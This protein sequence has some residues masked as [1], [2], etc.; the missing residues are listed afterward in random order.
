[1]RRSFRRLG[2]LLTGFLVAATHD[3]VKAQS[4]TYTVT[5]LGHFEEPTGMN[6]AGDVVGYARVGGRWHALL[7]RSGVLTDLGT[8]GAF[9]AIAFDIND[10]GQILLTL[11][12]SGGTRLALWSNGVVT[13]IGPTTG[14]GDHKM[15]SAGD[16][17]GE[18]LGNPILYSNG[19]VHV[20]P[21]NGCGNGTAHDVNE[22]A[23]IVV[24]RASFA[25]CGN[26]DTPAVWTNGVYQRLV[27]PPGAT[28]VE[29][30][31]INASG[32]IGVYGTSLLLY[33]P[34]GQGGYTGQNLGQLPGTTLC[35]PFGMNDAAVM[36][37]V[38][39]TTAFIWDAEHGL[40]DL[41]SLAA[42]PPG[43][44]LFSGYAVSNAGTIL[45]MG[46]DNGVRHGY[47]LTPIGNQPPVADAGSAQVV[48][49][50]ATVSLD[51]SASFDDNTATAQLAFSWTLASVPA[52]SAAQLTGANTM[53][54]TFVPDVVGNYVARLVVTDQNG[55]DSAPSDVVVTPNPP[56]SADAGLDQVVLVSSIVTLSGSASDA[57]G[58][59]L[60]FA[61]SLTSRPPG[62]SASPSNANQLTA[63]FIPD[64]AG[65]YIAR[66]TVS[67]PVGD[68]PPD[69]VRITATTASQY[70][71]TQIQAA[72]SIA[73]SLPSTAV[74]TGGNQNALSG[75]LAA[76]TVALDGGDT[77]EAIHKLQQAIS[78][79]DGCALLGAPDGNGPGRDWVT[80]CAAQENIY[81]LLR[82]A[83]EVLVP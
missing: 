27:S 60:S 28:A 10:A 23:S 34:D 51:G 44:S 76:A 74:T 63:S 47:L 1:M 72:A 48:R 18:S 39:G 45:A 41:T 83:L 57:D 64:V 70:A 4:A 9:D 58:D 24:G 37:G 7:W 52:G 8:F 35:A 25:A 50:G 69:E 16:V 14:Y 43:V 80:T 59:P 38:C 62:S 22:N 78:R 79:T 5:D 21:I 36:V 29:A 30:M 13:D 55:A 54:P 81:P 56:P 17:A 82:A 67:D 2:L 53:T 73:V 71:V 12:V 66:L 19:V 31:R 3:S 68:G 33:E 49:P 77:A 26:S 61:W 65:T 75:F 32:Q 20:L 46:I 6:A 11:N 40:R 42:L 15:N